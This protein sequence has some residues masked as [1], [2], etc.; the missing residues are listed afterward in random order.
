MMPPNACFCEDD[1][2][3]KQ[4]YRLQQIKQERP[5]PITRAIIITTMTPIPQIPPPPSSPAPVSSQTL[6]AVAPSPDHCSSA[7]NFSSPKLIMSS[8]M[9]NAHCAFVQLKCSEALRKF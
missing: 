8:C 1:Q 9:C 5:S 7:N 6:P 4:V 3:Y 2:A